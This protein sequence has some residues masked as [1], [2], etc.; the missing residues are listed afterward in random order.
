MLKE[1]RAFILQ[2]RHFYPDF[3]DDYSR[4]KE[5]GFRYLRIPASVS[6]AAV[7]QFD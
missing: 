4:H 1:K 6:F 2:D 3:P 7:D 5:Y